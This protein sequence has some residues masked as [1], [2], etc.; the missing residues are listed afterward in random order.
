M[1]TSDVTMSDTECDYCKA[2]IK[3]D[4]RREIVFVDGDPSC[5]IT[6]CAACADLAIQH[7]APGREAICFTCA[8]WR[9]SL[10][11][12]STSGWCGHFS[13]PCK[14]TLECKHWSSAEAPPSTSVTHDAWLTLDEVQAFYRW[15]EMN[16]AHPETAGGDDQPRTTDPQSSHY[17]IPGLDLELYDIIRAGATREELIG[18]L[19]W[20]L[21]ER[22]W[23]LGRKGGTEG[24]RSDARKI[25]VQSTWLVESLGDLERDS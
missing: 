6:Y 18:Y 22:V 20:S 1:A 19:R 23:R 16:Q 2:K 5:S 8:H 12:D 3:A 14:P 15:R 24:A 9:K 21:F 4:D 7:K 10:T 13:A 25:Q 11:S 17:A